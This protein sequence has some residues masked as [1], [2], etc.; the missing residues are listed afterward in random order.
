LGN[1]PLM[2]QITVKILLTSRR[3]GKLKT[4]P[5]SSLRSVM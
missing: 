4:T 5:A 2:E 1:T 3:D